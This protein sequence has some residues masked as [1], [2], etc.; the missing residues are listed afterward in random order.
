V[1]VP[2]VVGVTGGESLKQDVIKM[3]APDGLVIVRRLQ[4]LLLCCANI[5][6]RWHDLAVAAADMEPS[7]PAL[8]EIESAAKV[9]PS[10]LHGRGLY[11]ARDLKAG[12]LLTLYPIHAIGDADHSLTL[13]DSGHFDRATTWPY[14]VSCSHDGLERM[15]LPGD[16]WLDAN[17]EAALAAGWLGH[18]V[19]DAAVVASGSDADIEEYYEAARGQANVVLVP[20]SEAPPLMGWVTRCAIERGT[21]CVGTYGHDYWLSRDGGRPPAYTD[22]VLQ[23]AKSGWKAEQ[24]RAQQEVARRYVHETALLGALLESAVEGADG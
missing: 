16:I 15:G 8:L 20:L 1:S 4:A 3:L 12:T 24:S 17:P 18:M 2:F 7:A 9:S 19:N 6:L 23:A 11:A 13:D 10:R 14:R 5:E 22:R 21:E